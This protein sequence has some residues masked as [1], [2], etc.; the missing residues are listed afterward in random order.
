MKYMKETPEFWEQIFNH[1]SQYKEQGI[2]A[3]LAGTM[4]ILRGLYNGGGWKKTLIDGF[5]CAV[6]AWFVKDLLS[7][8]GLNQELA[9]LAS[10]FIGYLGVDAISKIMKGRAGVS[11]D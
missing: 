2:G 11:N 4:A 9:Y 1:L 6:F 10:V 7:L 5:M 3:G 8:I